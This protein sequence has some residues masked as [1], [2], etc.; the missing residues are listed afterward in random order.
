MLI[1]ENRRKCLRGGRVLP[2]CL[3]LVLNPMERLILSE[4]FYLFDLADRLC[5][6]ALQHMMLPLCP[7][8]CLLSSSPLPDGPH[9]A[10][11]CMFMYGFINSQW[12]LVN[13]SAINIACIPQWWSRRECYA[14]SLCFTCMVTEWN[15]GE[16]R[17]CVTSGN[18]RASYSVIGC[19]MGL[20]W[21]GSLF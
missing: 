13:A 3:N 18:Y 6:S 11:T 5:M 14:A 2:F 12:Q 16:G 8:F 10:Q 15:E 7:R 1:I 4:A 21:L 20:A 9:T 19:L 17:R